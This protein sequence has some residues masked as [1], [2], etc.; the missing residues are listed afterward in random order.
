MRYLSYKKVLGSLAYI[1][2]MREIEPL[3]VQLSD[4]KITFLR[5]R[6]TRYRGVKI[7]LQSERMNDREDRRSRVCEIT[8][9]Y[10]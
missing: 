2:T 1:C 8:R 9:V 3:V 10:S 6:E 5:R 4:T 7:L